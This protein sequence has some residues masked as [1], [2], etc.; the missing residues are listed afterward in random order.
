MKTHPQLAR[1]RAS[2]TG[3]YAIAGGSRPVEAAER[4]IAGG[5]RAVQ[6]RV[7]GA[8]SAELLEA[9]KRVV[10]AARGR[11]LVFV[12]DR[13][14]VA[15][16]AGADGVHVGDDDLSVPEARRVVGA[17]LLV[18]R[19]A[20]TL[21]DARR[22]VKE[23][24]DCVGFGPIFGT[25]SKEIDA[26]PRGIAMLREVCAALRVPVVAIGGIT[27]KNIGEVAGAG[28]ACAAVLSDLFDHR[29]VAARARLLA[30]A[31]EKG[32]P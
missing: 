17:S 5:A 6:V 12:N 14:D 9:A 28:A 2:L 22:A 21:D 31:F 27:A 7:K 29:D 18:G 15:F 1:R 11:A 10:Q 25:H 30:A 3:L 16:L 23:G 19:T 4:A 26:A 20:R 24:A 8:T 13:A 32:R